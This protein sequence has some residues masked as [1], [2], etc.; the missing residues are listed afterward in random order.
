MADSRYQ[1][2]GA[3]Y[4]GAAQGQFTFNTPYMAGHTSHPPPPPP[5]H[6]NQLVMYSQTMPPQMQG[7]SS[8]NVTPL[9]HQDA[10]TA[11]TDYQSFMQFME[12][13]KMMGQSHYYYV[14]PSQEKQKHEKKKDSGE[15]KK[16]R[17][18]TRK[19]LVPVKKRYAN[20]GQRE[21][22]GIKSAA[23]NVGVTILQ[24]KVNQV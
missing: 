14:P 2:G 8:D 13:Q 5:A 23:E 18:G 1:H 3:E 19:M 16:E 20:P 24:L 11:M 9:R 7:A 4:L 17:K 15:R 21:D 12:Y 10:M 22:A 6:Q